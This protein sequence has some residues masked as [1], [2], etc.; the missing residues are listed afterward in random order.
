V[1]YA[2]WEKKEAKMSESRALRYGTI[3]AALAASIAALA[4]SVQARI[5]WSG[6]NDVLKATLLAEAMHQCA[7]GNLAMSSHI[8]EHLQVLEYWKN[9][10]VDNP[11]YITGRPSDDMLAAFGSANAIFFILDPAVGRDITAKI[12]AYPDLP[13]FKAASDRA[14]NVAI[15]KTYID[16]MVHNQSDLVVTCALGARAIAFN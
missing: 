5:T 9:D 1:Q 8:R 13:D 2:R 10:K 7:L 14:G 15:L 3:V 16:G 6:R 4:G 11:A 12:S